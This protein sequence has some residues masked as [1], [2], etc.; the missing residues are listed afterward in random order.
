MKHDPNHLFESLIL[1]LNNPILLRINGGWK[2]MG[3]IFRWTKFKETRVL[4]LFPWALQIQ[5]YLP[6]YLSFSRCKCW[7]TI[8]KVVKVYYFS[9]RKSTQVYLEKSLTHTKTYLFQP[10]FSTCMGPMRTMCGSSSSLEVVRH[11]TFICDILVY[12][13]VWQFPQ[14]FS[15]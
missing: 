12:L 13:P 3:Y 15:S 1:M 5:K 4:K 9:W 2:L 8:S 7:H 14:I 11:W 10:I 6:I